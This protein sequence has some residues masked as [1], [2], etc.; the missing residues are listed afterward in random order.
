MLFAN[1][2]DINGKYYGDDKTLLY[3]VTAAI[4]PT[5]NFLYKRTYE[6]LL[7]KGADVNAKDNQGYTPLLVA[8]SNGICLY[9]NI[10]LAT[11]NNHLII[12]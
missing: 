8:V 7:S 1:G 10:M 6:Y 11:N 12:V 4:K 9:L 3:R 2:A 5:N